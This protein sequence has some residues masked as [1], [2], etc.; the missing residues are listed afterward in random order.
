[1]PK[2]NY[3]KSFKKEQNFNFKHIF[4]SF[5]SIF[6]TV[7]MTSPKTGEKILLLYYPSFKGLVSESFLLILIAGNVARARGSNVLLTSLV[8]VLYPFVF[9]ISGCLT[10][11]KKRGLLT[12]VI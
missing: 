6:C 5:F 1:M 7:I 11:E 4:Y 9:T 2:K 8:D 10:S 3:P 12:W